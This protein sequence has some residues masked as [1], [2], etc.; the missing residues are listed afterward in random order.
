MSQ[1]LYILCS[2][3]PYYIKKRQPFLSDFFN[4]VYIL[5]NVEDYSKET[6]DTKYLA[7][8]NTQNISASVAMMQQTSWSALFWVCSK[9]SM[10]YNH[11]I[12][13]GSEAVQASPS[14]LGHLTI[15]DGHQQK[16]LTWN[17]IKTIKN[18]VFHCFNALF[19]HLGVIWLHCQG[20]DPL[21]I[22][23]QPGSCSCCE[24]RALSRFC[25]LCNHQTQV[26]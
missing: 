20:A 6:S 2:F 5:D 24:K 13:W 1:T 19:S 22:A 3:K 12:S 14:S 10:V 16:M 21:R 9:S 4:V 26:N 18:K 11:F 25:C 15:A 7:S 23:S 17:K 8:V